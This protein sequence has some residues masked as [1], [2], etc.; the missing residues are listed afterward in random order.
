MSRTY[1]PF[2]T[3]D[4]SSLARSLRNQL[5]QNDH[6]PGH[7]ALLNMLARAIGHRN[8]QSLRA[9]QE[10]RGRLDAPGPAPEPVDFVQVQRLAR[11]FDPQ[12]RL[13]QWPSKSS[14]QLVCLWVLWSKLPSGQTFTEDELNRRIRANHLFGDHALLR[15]E[16]CDH[17]LLARTTDGRQYRRKERQPSPEGLALIRHLAAHGRATA[18]ARSGSGGGQ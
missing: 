12:G 18:A 15:R 1:I 13:A 9:Q 2:S 7:V 16:L 5:S 17:D 14:L 10:A 3:G 6:P 4:I 8:F 11:Y